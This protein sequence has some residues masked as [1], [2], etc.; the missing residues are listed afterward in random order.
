MKWKDETQQSNL[1]WKDEVQQTNL[2]WKD[3]AAQSASPAKQTPTNTVAP[4]I[5]NFRQLEAKQSAEN[6]KSAAQYSKENP[7]FLNPYI[8][9]EAAVLKQRKSNT[10]SAPGAGDSGLESFGKRLQNQQYATRFLEDVPTQSQVTTGNSFADMAAD[11][12]GFGLGL[13]GP[14]EGSAGAVTSGARSAFKIADRIM[15]ASLKLLDDTIIGRTA[16]RMAH[17]ATAG[18]VYGTAEGTVQGED[19]KGIANKAAEEAINFAIA[20]PI[21]GGAGEGA[22]TAIKDIAK[23][24][25]KA[26][27]ETKPG[28]L[29]NWR[30]AEKLPAE[31]KGL[32]SFDPADVPVKWGISGNDV[33]AKPD[34][35]VDPTGRTVGES[36]IL[37]S[38]GNVKGQDTAFPIAKVDGVDYTAD[39]GLGNRQ[40]SLIIT[41]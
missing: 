12:I 29:L 28:E 20:E 35:I 9:R 38:Q 10:Y 15:P 14:G 26:I 30:N 21:F 18:T 19:A 1:R 5:A 36:V 25:A 13:V 32:S 31:S 6:N 4:S 3:E 40:S 37:D 39:T 2:R 17:G 7:N 33:P 41:S 34:F 16:H 8:P 27:N 24:G 23:Y 22:T 11:F